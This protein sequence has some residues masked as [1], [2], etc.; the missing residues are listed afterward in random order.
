LALRCR[1]VLACAEGGSNIEVADR[2]GVN[3]LTVGKWRSRFVTDRLDGL[4]DEPRPGSPR[5]IGDDD[6]E[7][8]IVTTAGGHDG[9]VAIGDQP[10]LAGVRS[11]TTSRRQL[12]T[13]T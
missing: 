2:L 10:D 6:V 9:D 3:R 12:Q 5:T 7:R 11:Q 4:H 1:I 8:V 13:V